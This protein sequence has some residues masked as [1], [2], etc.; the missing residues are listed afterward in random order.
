VDYQPVRR[1]RSV[2]TTPTW[3]D[4]SKRPG[5]GEHKTNGYLWAACSVLLII[6][7][8]YAAYSPGTKSPEPSL[9]GFMALFSLW[10]PIL[11]FLDSP[12]RGD[13]LET[14]FYTVNL[15]V[16]LSIPAAVV[17]WALQAVIVLIVDGLKKRRT[18]VPS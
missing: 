10:G 12:S 17:G 16:G 5:H 1:D 13:L 6:L 7:V 15:V 8:A 11:L 2:Y 4:N 9:R 14:A 3:V 18:P